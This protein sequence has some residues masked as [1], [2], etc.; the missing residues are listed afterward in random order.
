MLG[1]PAGLLILRKMAKL[2][3]AMTVE[4]AKRAIERIEKTQ[5]AQK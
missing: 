4:F 2:N 1:D 3:D 5:G